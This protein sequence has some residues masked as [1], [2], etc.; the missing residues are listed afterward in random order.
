MTG[1]P[2]LE[3]PPLSQRYFDD[4][5]P[6]LAAVSAPVEVTEAAIV[7]FATAFD[8][9]AMHVDPEAARGG[10][11]GGLIASGWHTT[12]L[13]MRLLVDTFLNPAAS[14]ASPGVDELRWHRPVRPGDVLR[15]RFSVLSA[16]PSRSKPDRGLV[17]IGIEL[18]NQDEELVMSQT[19]LVLQRRRP[20]VGG[21]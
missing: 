20:A 10:E 18:V 13:M 8:P 2:P 1:T 14:I 17:R 5:V 3:T 11:F 16:T 6:G 15:G 9:H 19:M 12:A 4:Y 7:A 21:G